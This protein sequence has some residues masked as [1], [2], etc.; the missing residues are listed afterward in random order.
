MRSLIFNAMILLPVLFFSQAPQQRMIGL[1][2]DMSSSGNGHGS[3]YFPNVSITNG[4]N[5]VTFG[6]LIHKRSM[7]SNGC[8]IGYSF[9]LS[10]EREDMPGSNSD[11]FQLNA[12]GY[13]QYNNLLELSHHVETM[14]YR[15]EREPQV[16]WNK[17]KYATAEA[18]AGLQL[19][20][21]ITSR[22]TWK[23]YAGISV[24]RHIRGY[25]QFNRMYHDQ[26]GVTLCLGTG[27]QVSLPNF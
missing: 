25:T 12:F 16:E 27:I 3:F 1:G 14:E 6:P 11:L 5:T 18:T 15:I 22:I 4:R 21:N 8:R 9:N 20:I 10:Q 13:V 24:Y 26:K 23:N 19:R 2:V 7:E 17:V